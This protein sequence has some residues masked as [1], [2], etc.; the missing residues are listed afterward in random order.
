MALQLAPGLTLDSVG[1]SITGP[2]SFSRTG[3]DRR[4]PQHHDLGDDR[5]PAGGRRLHA[6]AVGDGLER[7]HPVRGDVGAV[8]GHGARDDQRER[9]PA[10]PGGA[11][12][13]QRAWSTAPSTSVR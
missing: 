2:G 8:L 9:P 5:R 13:G 10:L 12:Q 1:Y 6:H 7:D 11:D 4:Q 3:H